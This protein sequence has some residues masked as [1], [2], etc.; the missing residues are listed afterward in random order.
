VIQVLRRALVPAPNLYEIPQVHRYSGRRGADQH[1]A[2]FLRVPELGGRIDADVP[3]LGLDDAAGRGHVAGAQHVLDLGCLH[4]ER[5][6]PI[7]RVL[8]VDLFGEDPRAIHFGNNGDTLQRPR[9]EVREVVELPVRVAVADD[10]RH[11]V[12]GRGRI[13]HN[14]RPP[15]VRVEVIRLQSGG[16]ELLPVR[17]QLGV[18]PGGREIDSGAAPGR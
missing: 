6:E 2:N 4:V 16:D 13:A 11:P 12:S 1:V 14:D 3:A 18:G 5:G 9:E 7:V 8:E 15:A 17:T 10:L